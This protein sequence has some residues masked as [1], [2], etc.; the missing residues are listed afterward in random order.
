M[1]KVKKTNLAQTIVSAILI[2]CPLC[3]SDQMEP[4]SDPQLISINQISSDEITP[5]HL[6]PLP[7]N[8][9]LNN[10]RVLPQ[11]FEYSLWDEDRLS[12]GNIL[13]DSTQLTFQLSPSSTKKNRYNVRF[14]WPGGLVKNGRLTIRDNSGKSIFSS[15][16]K[17][18]DITISKGNVMEDHENLRSEI[19]TFSVNELG[20]EFIESMR[21]LPFLMFCVYRETELT[22]INICSKE[23]YLSLQK[24]QITIRPRNLNKK[25]A[26]VEINGGKIGSQ[27]VIYLNDSNETI[28]F[29]SQ[30]QSGSFLEMDIRT[31]DVDFNDIFQDGDNIVLTATGAEPVDEKIIKK[32]SD[33]TWS[34][35]L[36]KDRPVIY[37]KGDGDFPLRQEINIRGP[38]PSSS[39]RIYAERASIAKTYSSTLEVLVATPQNAKLSLPKSEVSASI[40]NKDSEHYL[41]KITK[42]PKGTNQRYLNLNAEGNTFT[43]SLE[44]YRAPA[45]SLYLG[46]SYNFSADKSSMRAELEW[47]FDSF[48]KL[49]SS[50]SKNHWGINLIQDNNSNSTGLELLWRS[51]FG[52]HM[53]DDTWGLILALQDLNSNSGTS[54]VYGLGFFV[55]KS[56]AQ[57]EMQNFMNFCEFKIHQYFGSEADTQRSH[58]VEFNMQ[59]YKNILGQQFLFFRY[60]LGVSQYDYDP[61]TKSN[62]VQ[63]QFQ[64]GIYWTF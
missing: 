37:L 27:G 11:R 46:G 59:A 53:I 8:A 3:L 16:F 56:L 7:F 18:D 12:V 39:N 25:N 47:W 40:K 14:T 52:I 4:G 57:T 5:S 21:H 63:T 62:E 45:Y 19:A 55:Q 2:Y 28:N 30:T 32:I 49:N 1:T 24:G 38:I 43:A 36:P 58:G 42:I 10:V 20:P 29:K 13:I 35:R 34:I 9:N 48:L 51:K 60:G 54:L 31:K 6:V 50:W 33:T 15:T 22:K 23:L 64:S 44:T 26:Q 61:L 41:W 17:K